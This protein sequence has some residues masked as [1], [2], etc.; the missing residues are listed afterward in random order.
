[1]LPLLYSHPQG[2]T[3]MMVSADLK[4]PVVQPPT[5]QDCLQCQNN[6]AMALSIQILLIA[7]NRD[8]TTFPVTYSRAVLLSEWIFFS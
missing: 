7:V 4:R 8:A 6:T 2:L 3:A 1:M 5:W